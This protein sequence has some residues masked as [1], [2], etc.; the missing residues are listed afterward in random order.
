LDDN[1]TIKLDKAKTG[2]TGVKQAALIVLQGDSLGTSI[3][4]D[5]ETVTIGRGSDCELRLDD[6]L[7]SRQ[8]ARLIYRRSESGIGFELH[9]LGS[10]NGTFVN[11]KLVEDSV[12][13]IDGDK[14][15]VGRHVFKYALLD[16]YE[17]AF[18]ER[19][20]QLIIRDDLTNL[21]TQRSFYVDF[22]RQVARREAQ[23]DPGS[24]SILMM[25][26]DHFKGVNDRYGHLVGSQTIKQ[27]GEIIESRLRAGDVA[28]RYGGEEYVAYLQDLPMERAVSIAERL[29]A[30]VADHVIV[31]TRKG[32]EVRL[33]VTI[34]IGIAFYPLDGRTPLELIERADLALYRAK[35]QGRNRVEIY[36]PAVDHVDEAGYERLDF[37][38]LLRNTDSEA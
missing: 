35:K 11:G 9:E 26:L 4:L 17:S 25:D 14:I 31:V 32:Q 36:D 24:L 2:P 7:A 23:A 19:L 34:S 5:R 21:L 13:L 12:V 27:I 30:A 18:Q 37:S 8:H 33:Q 15:R 20:E 1:L 22:E 10:T 16:E 28:A 29:R 6:N 38:P 3:P